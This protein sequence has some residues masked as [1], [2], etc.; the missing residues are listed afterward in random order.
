MQAGQPAFAIDA[1]G[2][3]WFVSEG[4]RVFGQCD[5]M[6]ASMDKMRQD[7]MAGISE[8]DRAMMEQMMQSQVPQQDAVV[9]S[10]GTKQIAGYANAGYQIGSSDESCVSEQLLEEIESE[11]GKSYI[12]ELQTIFGARKAPMGMRDPT[13]EAIVEISKKGFSME[14]RLRMAAIQGMNAAMLEPIPKEQRDQI[15]A[16]LGATGAGQMQGSR[17][18]KVDTNGVMPALDLTQ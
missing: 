4:Q 2:N 3:C 1:E 6:F 15:M 5:A 9:L 11:M 18:I 13:Q 17:V 7:M 10:S 16:Q 14:N 8:G 12:M